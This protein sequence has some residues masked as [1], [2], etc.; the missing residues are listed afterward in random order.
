MKYNRPIA[1]IILLILIAGVCFFVAQPDHRNVIENIVQNKSEKLKKNISAIVVPHH[2]LDKVD[3]EQLFS[4]IS[5]DISVKTIV[6]VST[7]HF[8]TGNANI[9]TTKKEWQLSTGS[10][11]ANTD[12]TAALVNAKVAMEDENAFSEEHGIKNLLPDITQ[13]FP[14]TNLV[15]IIIKPGTSDEEIAKLNQSLA[16]NCKEDCLLVGSVDFSHYQPGAIASIHDDL[17]IRAL[18]NLEEEKLIR[19]EVDS[20]ETLRLTILWAKGQETEKFNLFKNTNSGLIE[21]NRD[22]ESTSYVLG[23]YSK[24]E[25][26]PKNDSFTFMIGGDMMFDRNIEYHFQGDKLVNVMKNFGDRVFAGTDLSIVNLEGPINPAPL[27][28][29]TNHSLVFNFQPNTVDVLKYMGVNAVSLANNHTLNNGQKGLSNTKKVLPE[30]GIAYVGQDAVFNDE[31]VKI[32]ENGGAIKLAVITIDCLNTNNDLTATIKKQK[33]LGNKVLV[34]PHWGTEYEQIHSSSQEKL[35]HSWVDAGADFV[36]GGH[37]H[38]IQDAEVYNGKPIFYSMGNLLFDQDFSPET[39][40]GLIVAVKMSSDGTE[41][42]L[43]PTISKSYQPQLL[44]GTE[45]TSFLTKFRK[46]LG[47][48]EIEKSYGYDTIMLDNR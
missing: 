15:P 44:S 48:S 46:Y 40:R 9:L 18:N 41:L 3:R 33:D 11:L 23:Y 2:D 22:G 29:E 7:N 20:K 47:A 39:Q 13:Y 31:S 19:S 35:A 16:E 32:F 24:G 34:Y 37:P 30:N 14:K 45:K 10:I 6:L 36:F 25:V 21:N 28:P 26:E 1:F 12:I 42:V 27:V 17:A 5:G 43:L 8:N 38:V 4:N